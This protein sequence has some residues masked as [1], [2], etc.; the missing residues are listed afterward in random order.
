MNNWEIVIIFRFEVSLETFKKD[1]HICA[2]HNWLHAREKSNLVKLK[3]PFLGEWRKE[4]KKKEKKKKK[5]FQEKLLLFEKKKKKKI[6]FYIFSSSFS[7]FF[8][9]LTT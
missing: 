8:P 4:E 6:F 7:T 5:K 3:F 1:H 9:Y 2:V